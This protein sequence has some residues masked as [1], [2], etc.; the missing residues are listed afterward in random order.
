[1]R[2]L[3]QQ[4]WAAFRLRVDPTKRRT[5]ISRVDRATA[6]RARSIA[7]F[8]RSF[9]MVSDMARRMRLAWRIEQRTAHAVALQVL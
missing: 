7:L 6:F 3:I 9:G 4:R 5:E 1:M 8:S 2:V